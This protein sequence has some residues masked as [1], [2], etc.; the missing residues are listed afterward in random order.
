MSIVTYGSKDLTFFLLL[1]IRN[2]P[3]KHIAHLRKITKNKD[4]FEQIP[5]SLLVTATAEKTNVCVEFQFS[6]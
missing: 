2:T 3:R 5:E 6:S 1:V 4:T